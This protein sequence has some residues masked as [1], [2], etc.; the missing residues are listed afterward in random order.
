MLMGWKTCSIDFDSAFV[1][2]SLK[3][4]VW[5]HV[6]RG[7]KSPNCENAC[8]ELQK[9]LYG[10]TI[11]PKLWYE[12]LTKAFLKLGFQQSKHDKCLFFKHKIMVVAYVDDCGIG[13][14]SEEQITE[15]IDGLRGLGFNLTREGNFEE[16]LGIKIDRTEWDAHGRI[17]MTQQGLIQKTISYVGMQDCNPNWTPAASVALGANPDDESHESNFDWNYATAVGML[18]YLAINTRPDIAFAVSQVSRF[19]HHPKKAHSTAVKTIARY[20]KRTEDKGT[21]FEQDPYLN[22]PDDCF[23][24]D[25]FVDADFAGLY[26]QEPDRSPAGAKSRTGYIIR[27]AGNPLIWKSKLQTEISL[28]TLESEYSALSQAMRQLLP[29]RKLILE[30]MLT[31]HTGDI[32]KTMIKCT[33]FE[34]NNGALILATNQRI[35]SRTKYFHVK[36]HHFWHHITNGDVEVLKIATTE[37]L[38]DYLTKGLTREAFEYLRKQVQGW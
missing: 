6:P 37:Q 16:F 27:L 10:L 1:Q 7:F 18:Q 38:A 20:L 30:L 31:L 13:S 26:K 12:H 24:L 21:Y 25:C 8:L 29:L 5:I 35:T 15:L 14:E 17:H 36:W 32:L 22:D 11:A 3:D 34:D 19:T 2:A 4:P 23:R 33:V 28:S 9:S